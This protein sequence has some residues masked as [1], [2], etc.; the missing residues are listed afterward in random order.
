[1]QQ[2]PLLALGCAC[3]LLRMVAMY[4]TMSAGSQPVANPRILLVDD[5]ALFRTGLRM[6]LAASAGVGEIIEAGTLDEALAYA[7]E[8]VDVLLLD[9]LLPGLNGLEGITL[10]AKRMAK[11][12]IVM[13]SAQ[14]D[15]ASIHSARLRGAAG[16]VAKSAAADEVFLAIEAV[17]AGKTYFSPA[18]AAEFPLQ[19]DA[20]HSPQAPLTAR[21][22]EVLAQLCAGLSNKLIARKLGM[23]EN[24]VRVHVTAI[25]AYFNVTSR[26]QAMLAAQRMG[27]V[28]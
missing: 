19:Q 28:H 15:A 22:L 11:T 16:F 9:I 3:Y 18:H 2:N 14:A 6:V 1:M 8:Q 20:A 7:G 12:P 24:T 5:H 21:Q 13:L 10:L 27:I 23:A 26:S 25:F 17:L 4:K